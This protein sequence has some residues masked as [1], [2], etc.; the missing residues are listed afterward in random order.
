MFPADRVSAPD[1]PAGCSSV[2][3]NTHDLQ[4]LPNRTKYF[5]RRLSDRNWANDH[6]L[7]LLLRSEHAPRQQVADQCP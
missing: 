7:V 1:P 4:C 3:Q 6:L 5:I 2:S